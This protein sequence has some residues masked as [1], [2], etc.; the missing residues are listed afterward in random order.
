MCRNGGYMD[1]YGYTE[2]QFNR[3]VELFNKIS[4][5]GINQIEDYHEATG[6][7]RHPVKLNVKQEEKK[8]AN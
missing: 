6:I 5:T 7:L 1:Y 8:D 2:E 3:M 4:I